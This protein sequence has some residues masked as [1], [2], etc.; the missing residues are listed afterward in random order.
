MSQNNEQLSKELQPLCN[1]LINEV[2][3]LGSNGS[4]ESVIGAAQAIVHATQS[5]QDLY[6]HFAVNKCEIIVMRLFLKWEAFQEIPLQESISFS[7]LAGK[8]GAEVELVGKT[9][10]LAHVPSLSCKNRN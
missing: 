10:I 4:R 1:N 2:A 5:A 7:E 3:A 8:I 6:V 9:F